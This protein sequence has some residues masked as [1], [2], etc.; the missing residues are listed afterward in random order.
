[1]DTN[2]HVDG[3]PDRET[4]GRGLIRA[5]TLV[6]LLIG[7]YPSA[8]SA[9]TL[10]SGW[11][12]T[13]IGAALLSGV[14]SFSDGV[15][16]VTASGAR[17][18]DTADQFTFVYHEVVGDSVITA[19][20]MSLASIDA[21]AEAGLLIRE[22]LAPGSRQASVM[23]SGASTVVTKFR[24]TT[25]GNRVVIS[26]SAATAPVWLRLERTMSTLTA[27]RSA[28][29]IAWTPIGT[30]TLTMT[31]TVY[32]GLAAAGGTIAT[33]TI[34]TS[35][36]IAA[37]TSLT[38]DGTST[39][40]TSAK[41]DRVNHSPKVS[42]ASPSNRAT[43]TAPATVSVTATARDVD[44]TVAAVEFYAGSTLIGSDT[45][46]PYGVTWSDVPGG[47]YSLTA[48]A[49]DDKGAAT[50]SA[51]RSIT[52]TAPNQAPTVSL[53]APANGA[54]FTA[55]ATITVAATAGDADGTVAAVEF[56]AGTTVIGSDTTTPYSVTWSNVP[57]GTYAL[58]A[59]ARDNVGATRTSAARSIMVN[60]VPAGWTSS[61]VGGPAMQGMASVS[62]NTFTVRGAGTDIW[63][64]TDQFQFVHQSMTDALDV[65]ARVATLEPVHPWTQGGVMI[66][67]S[68]DGTAAY[69]ALV[70]T[71]ANGVS[72]IWRS[73]SGAT[74]SYT[75]GGE[76]AAPVWLKLA[77]RGAIVTAFRSADGVS[78][79]SLGQQTVTLPSMVDV[80]LVVTSHDVSQLATATFDNVTTVPVSSSN[81]PPAVTLTAPANGATFT[82]PATITVTATASDTDGTVTAVEFYAGGTTLIGSDTSSPYSITWSNVPAGT[83]NLTAV[84]RD[85]SAGMTVSVAR[86][87]AVDDPTMPGKA[88][89]TASIDHDT[90]VDYYVVEIFPE[91]ANP[92]GANAVAAQNIGKP[93]RVNGE[94][95][96]DVR[97]TIASLSPG[98]YIA[99]VTAF[100]SDGSARSAPSPPFAR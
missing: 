55:P 90:A 86:T 13:D 70:V 79:S 95:E 87:I 8:A 19:R 22:S 26:E 63:D 32:V 64:P 56:Y 47:T 78:W 40:T 73:S 11:T 96:A 82:A 94:C 54:S 57:A 46:S 53:S 58:T 62:S 100:G 30:V 67:A 5:T 85:D 2:T 60:A 83:Y 92:A 49:R 65:S 76:G 52:V 10:P 27:F 23:L 33:P 45:T 75:Y 68:L 80:G 14:A 39:T 48:V 50:T 21:G 12:T 25:D 72:F 38:T 44:G 15:L 17:A 93:P 41:F 43:Y 66:R 98:S 74:S 88:V 20:V 31:S 91:G 24:S 16:S 51:A 3:A 89:F 18:L 1:M 28:D 34:A 97:N 36:T 42:I 61:D 77:R 7:L 59:V 84:A 37:T 4:S 81:Q 99:T 29:G 9:Q 69:A 71:P 35:G 6:A